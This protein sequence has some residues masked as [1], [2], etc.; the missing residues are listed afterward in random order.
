MTLATQPTLGLRDAHGRVARDLRVSLTDRC[1]L[2]CSYCMPAEGLAWLPGRTIL[3]DTE[4]VRLVRVAVELLGVDTVRFTGGEPLLRPGLA[5]IIAAVRELTTDRGGPPGVALT[6]NGIGLDAH[7]A[8]LKAAGLERVNVS[9]DSL[10]RQRYAALARR[11]RLPEV[12]AGLAAAE[13]AGLR[14]VKV[15]TVVMRGVNEVD[16]LPLAE[17]CLERGYQLRF[18]E[19]MPLGPRHGWDRDAMVPAA[20]VLARLQQHYRLIP[21]PGRGAAPSEDW[22]VLDADGRVRGR[23]GVIAS[24]TR[25]FCGACDR[26][27]LTADGQLRTCLFAR[28]ET[29]LRTPLRSGATDLELAELWQGA[30]LTKARGHGI[31]DPGFAPPVRTM[32]SI[33]G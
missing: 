19:Q 12:L 27:R 3:T 4:V 29:D 11:D 7:V 33:G 5:G 2:R 1:N 13:A 31:D 23:I 25:P 20:E 18:I 32:S 21:L 6:T 8:A 17:Y 24:V 16:V 30:H 28:T 22:Q 15:N 10:N 14:P 26:T 9:L